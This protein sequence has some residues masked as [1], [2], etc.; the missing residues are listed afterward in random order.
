MITS[1]KENK[2]KTSGMQHC[3]F[4]EGKNGSIAICF[5]FSF[6]LLTL[7]LFK[8]TNSPILHLPDTYTLNENCELLAW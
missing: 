6:L 4:I 8:G 3:A 5:F 2:Q 7:I 1:F